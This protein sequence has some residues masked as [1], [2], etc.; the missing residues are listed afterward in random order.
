MGPCKRPGF[1]GEGA[2]T[3]A[4][5]K[6]VQAI[7]D[8]TSARATD[9]GVCWLRIAVPFDRSVAKTALF[10]VRFDDPHPPITKPE[11]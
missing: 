6:A 2:E 3:L 11:R 4:H 9:T 5:G 10:A 1:T 8:Q 7:R